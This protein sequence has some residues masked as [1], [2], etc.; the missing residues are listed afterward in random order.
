MSFTDVETDPA[1]PGELHDSEGSDAAYVPPPSPPMASDDDI[2]SR[3]TQPVAKPAN[4]SSSSR[5]TGPD[6]QAAVSS[7]RLE[8]S[9]AVS[10]LR[11]RTQGPLSHAEAEV[12]Q[13]LLRDT[14]R[15][16]KVTTEQEDFDRAQLTEDQVTSLSRMFPGVMGMSAKIAPEIL[17][18][19]LADQLSDSDKLALV[20]DQMY[21]L[22][23]LE[24]DVKNLKVQNYTMNKNLS[25]LISTAEASLTQLFIIYQ[26]YAHLSVFPFQSLAVGITQLMTRFD[27]FEAKVTPRED[28]IVPKELLEARGKFQPFKTGAEII[29]YFHVCLL[30]NLINFY[31][32]VLL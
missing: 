24:R 31:F 18:A 8:E 1:A 17:A 14:K 5:T 12:F 9:E 15:R 29:R 7:Q 19:K 20:V 13:R 4:G 3:P 30:L 16:Y 22:G 26:A 10:D 28:R 27:D 25:K 23:R 2:F 6:D 32:P 11:V 21:L